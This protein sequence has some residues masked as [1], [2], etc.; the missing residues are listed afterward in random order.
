MLEIFSKISLSFVSIFVF[1]RGL[2]GYD[3]TNRDDISLD[4]GEMKAL[5]KI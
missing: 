1:C 4:K 3:E 5:H 2:G